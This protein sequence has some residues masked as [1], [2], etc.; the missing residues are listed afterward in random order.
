M[1]LAHLPE[2]DPSLASLALWCTIK[3]GDGPHTCVSGDVIHIAD[4]F[5]AL[6][7]REQIGVLG[8]HVLHVALRHETALIDLQARLGHRFAP[9]LFNL[10]A[11]C[12]INTC[13]DRADIALPRPAVLLAELTNAVDFDVTTDI[14]KEP[15]AWEIERL[16]HCLARREEDVAASARDYAAIHGFQADIFP[17]SHDD[18][19]A[20]D[21]LVWRARL[22]RAAQAGG[23]AGRGIGFLLGQLAEIFAGRVPWERILRKLLARNLQNIPR[24]SDRRPR[25]AWIAADSAARHSGGP[26]PVY[27][28]ALMRQSL[29]P[30]IV[31][32]LDTSGSVTETTMSL[33]AGELVG[34]ASKTGAEVHVMWFDEAVYEERVVSAVEM[35]KTLTERRFTRDG[36]TSFVDVLERARQQHP[37]VVVI[38]SDMAGPMGPNPNAPVIWATPRAEHPTPAFGQVVEILG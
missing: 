10:A 38:L 8:H 33:F 31:V 36:G 6:P 16:Y 1:A 18:R 35:R 30:R 15:A 7:L 5:T 3:D 25:S 19:V 11:D 28:P 4:S 37:S 26:E 17:H 2:T 32:G 23:A 34:I 24:R 21:A 13:L 22:I 27:D 20:E 14:G 29:Q 9:D 12:I